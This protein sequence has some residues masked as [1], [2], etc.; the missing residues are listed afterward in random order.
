[1]DDRVTRVASVLEEAEQVH[2]VVSRRT[3]GADPDW[4]LFYAWWLTR[5]SDLPEVLGAAPGLA[6]LTVE[7]TR[8]DRAYRDRPADGAQ[9]EPW[10][11]FYAREL[12]A[13]PWT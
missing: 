9:S 12:L 6:D 7:L 1:M 13:R 4:A 8:L 5:W 11:Q 2:A 10:P 3:A